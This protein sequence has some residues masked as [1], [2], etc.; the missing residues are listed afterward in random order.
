MT[1]PSVAAHSATIRPMPRSLST[2]PSMIHQACRPMSRKTVFSRTN[3]IIR[4]LS[5]SAI[6]DCAVCRT[7]AL[8]PSSSPATTTAITPEAWTSSAATNA[9][10]GHHQRDRAVE[11]RVGDDVLAHLGDDQE[12]RDPDQHPAAGRDHEV[13][14]DVE[15]VQPTPGGHGQRGAQRD[16]RGGVVEQR[17]ALQDRHDP[18]RQA[19]P[20]TDR[21]RRHRVRRGDHRTERQRHRPGQVRQQ[22]LGHRGDADGGEDDQTDREQQD[23]S[24][25]GVEV[26]ERGALGGGVQQRRQQPEQDHVSDRGGS[27]GTCGT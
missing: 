13:Q 17:L 20:A 5:R 22:Q 26:D 21:G 25:V 2:A 3:E 7:G 14:A 24:P 10:E 16:Q 6:R 27:R 8:W 15:G 12:E 9:D 18:A 19:D 4:Q 23:R 11:H 1:A